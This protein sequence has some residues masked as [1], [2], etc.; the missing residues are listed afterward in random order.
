MVLDYYLENNKKKIINKKPSI[1][2]K[3]IPVRFQNLW[4]ALV[5]FPYLYLF[6]KLLNV[7]INK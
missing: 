5:N 6:K 7:L 3:V 1:N 4:I 2:Q